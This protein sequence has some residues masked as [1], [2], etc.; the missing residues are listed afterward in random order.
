LRGRFHTL[1]EQT[2][3]LEER[4]ALLQSDRDSLA[5]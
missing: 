2:R 5:R 1:L 4:V 3:L